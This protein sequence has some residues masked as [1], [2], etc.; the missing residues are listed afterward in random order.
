MKPTAMDDEHMQ[1]FS[2]IMM[3][4]HGLD[5]THAAAIIGECMVKARGIRLRWNALMERIL[6]AVR[7]M[8][9]VK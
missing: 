5:A 6:M 7:C 3:N 4:R 8:S 1:A 9:M 2:S